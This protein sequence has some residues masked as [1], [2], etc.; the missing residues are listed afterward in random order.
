M[1]MEETEHKVL[2]DFVGLIGYPLVVG[3][4]YSELDDLQMILRRALN[5]LEPRHTPEWVLKLSDKVD[6][7][8]GAQDEQ[9]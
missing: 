8:V 2:G 4:S 9:R 3:F 7:L 5:T 1:A 6:E